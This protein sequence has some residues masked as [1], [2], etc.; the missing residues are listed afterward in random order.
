MN[1]LDEKI[2]TTF[3]EESVFKNSEKYNIFLVL[4][5]PHLL[6]IG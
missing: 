5:Y 2:K 6:K 3:V 4:F 1:E